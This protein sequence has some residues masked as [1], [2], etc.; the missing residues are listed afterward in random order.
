[1]FGY[2]GGVAVAVTIVVF[3]MVAWI[4]GTP[5]SFSE[6]GLWSFFS[7]GSIFVNWVTA[8]LPFF[9]VRG[10][11]GKG[12]FEKILPCMLAG[13]AVLFLTLLDLWLLHAINFRAPR[14]M[15]TSADLC[16]SEL[17]Q[18]DSRAGTSSSH[19]GEEL[20]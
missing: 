20:G 1:M 8:L 11:V 19:F 2:L 4:K 16:E 9:I 15:A 10:L 13:I 12:R 3:L 6:L 14:K 5:F 18:Q 17:W 7:L